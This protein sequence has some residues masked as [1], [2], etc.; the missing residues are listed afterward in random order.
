MA[1][2]CAAQESFEISPRFRQ[3]I[4]ER[5]VR[6]EQ[7]GYVR[8][9][10]RTGGSGG[11]R[12]VVRLLTPIDEWVTAPFAPQTRRDS[13]RLGEGAGAAEPAAPGRLGDWPPVPAG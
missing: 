10:I 6:L 11:T 4:E 13:G 9:E 8:R 12:S 3:M 7:A 5:I 1:I 2:Q